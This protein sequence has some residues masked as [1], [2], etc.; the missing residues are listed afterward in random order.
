MLNCLKCKGRGFCGKS[1]C[2]HMVKLNSTQKAR[3]LYTNKDFQGPSPAPF[4]GRIGYPNV[5]IGILST[6][7]IEKDKNILDSPREWARK[8]MDIPSVVDI[9]SSLLNARKIEDVKRAARL[10]LTAQE[11]GLASSPVDVEI[12]MKDK[13]KFRINIYSH[14][15]PTG[16]AADLEKATITSNPNIERKVDKVNSDTDLKAT[17]AIK[18]LHTSGYDENFLSKLL[19]VGAVG[20]GRNRKFVPTR[21]SIT[22]TDDT[23]ANS[24]IERIKQKP[25]IDTINSFLGEYLGNYY[26]ILM[27]PGAWSYE[28]FESYLPN[29]SWN[30]SGEI[31]FS[32][33]YEDLFGRKNYAENCA[34]GYYSVRLAI[35]EKL[36]DMKRQASCLAIRVITKDYSVPLGV[37]VTREAARNALSNKAIEFSSKELI[38]KY[39]LMLIK[40]K[41][42]FNAENIFRS[43]KLMERLDKQKTLA[44]FQ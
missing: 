41:F 27:F 2:A 30:M 15:A 20:L 5:N 25:S 40:K 29:A 22:A 6:P 32:T 4:I 24:I 11:I 33:D 14:S 18:Y 10:S 17:D 9:R 16:P 31:S 42:S 39:A 44:E 1:M 38:K 19:S 36:E 23:I 8:R 34:G 21:W 35:A 28:L 3:T 7:D 37:W 26:L 13:P 12:N 43:S